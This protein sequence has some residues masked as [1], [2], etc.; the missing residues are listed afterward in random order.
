MYETQVPDTD[1]QSAL[2]PACRANKSRHDA[3]SATALR[4]VVL[5]KVLLKANPDYV[6]PGPSVACGKPN[7]DDEEASLAINGYAAIFTSEEGV[8]W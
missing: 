5:C 4:Y 8:N 3:G 2:F 6:C 7:E 1:S